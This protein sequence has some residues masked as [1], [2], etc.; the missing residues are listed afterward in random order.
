MVTLTSFHTLMS[1]AVHFPEVHFF[2]C[3]PTMAR[4]A[5]CA[6]RKR[7]VGCH[8]VCWES[9]PVDSH[10]LRFMQP[11]RAVVTVSLRYGNLFWF[12]DAAMEL[13]RSGY[14][15]DA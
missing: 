4:L 2:L 10:F 8:I 3:S 5:K 11:Q 1:A 15:F 14:D 12:S 13:R 9:C 6:P 7:A